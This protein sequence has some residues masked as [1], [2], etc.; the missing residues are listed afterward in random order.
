DTTN[1]SVISTDPAAG[2]V[3]VPRRELVTALPRPRAVPRPI[4]VTFSE[5]MSQASVQ[6][7]FSIVTPS[8]FNGGSFKWSGNTMQYTPPDFFDPGQ[9][10]TFSIGPGATDLAGNPLPQLT[11]SFR[12]RNRA[13][14]DFYAS[15]SQ[16]SLQ[17]YTYSAT[18]CTSSTAVGD[19]T[20]AAAGDRSS[21]FAPVSMYRGFMT[22]SIS[23]LNTL[24]NVEIITASLYA[25]QTYCSGTPYVATFGSAIEAWHVNY[26]PTLEASDCG[27]ANLGGRRYVL[28]KDTTL[29]VKSVGVT[30]AVEDD[31]AN[32]VSRGARSQFRIQT[33][34]AATDGDTTSDYCNFATNKATTG[35]PFLRVTYEYD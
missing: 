6:G 15:T 12:V 32:R 7:A 3:G 2:A 34:L 10:V 20:V 19:T 18:N 22:F 21:T 9:N 33:P 17:G 35:R 16:H 26:G 25:T 30:T 29:E 5:A 28:S 1:P 8:G 27:S 13:T 4:K 23:P 11:R 14:T 31:F 24:T